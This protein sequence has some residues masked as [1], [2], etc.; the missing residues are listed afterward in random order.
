MKTYNN[1]YPKICE[2]ENIKLAIRNASKGKRKK[3]SVQYALAHIDEVAAN[4][5]Q[6][7]LNETW[8]PSEFHNAKIINDG[9]ELKKRLIVCPDFIHEQVVHHAVMQ[10]VYPLYERKFYE[11]TCGS[12]K[13]RGMQ[14]AINHIRKH[15]QNQRY[16]CKLDV[17]KFFQSIRPSFVFKELRR[18]IKCKKTLILF[19]KILRGNKIKFHNQIIK[20]GT[21]IGFYTSPFFANILLLR[22]DHFIK[23]N[24][25]INCYSRYMDD[26]ILL[27][28]NKRKLKRAIKFIQFFLKMNKLNAKQPPQIHKITKFTFLGYKITKERFTLRHKLSLKIHRCFR[29]FE[30]KLTP[31]NYDRRRL[32]SYTGLLKHSDCGKFLRAKQHLIRLARLNLSKAK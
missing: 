7:L 30:Q 29:R 11:F 23:N 13:G 10:I 12:I 1:L 19:S 17:S 6:E 21:P 16:Y 31:T 8:K 24:F 14:Y 26:M 5:Q 18:T 32:L 2:L 3:E 15:I 28:T 4:I 27:D 9:V 25:Q 22:L 20:F